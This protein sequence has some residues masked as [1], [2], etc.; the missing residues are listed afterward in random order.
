MAGAVAAE[1]IMPKGPG[2][3]Q[4][5]PQ[6]GNIGLYPDDGS[7]SGAAGW[8]AKVPIGGSGVRAPLAPMTINVIQYGA[9]GNGVT[10]DTAAINSAIAAANAFLALS[11]SQRGCIVYF[12]AGI[13]LVSAALTAINANGIR[14]RGEGRG[15]STILVTNGTGDIFS[16]TAGNEYCEVDN[17]QFFASV[18]R[19]A[20]AFINT[21]GANDVRI[22]DFV[23]SGYFVGISISNSSIKVYVD[24]GVIS[25]A[26]SATA[27]GIL[28]SNGAAGDTYLSDVVMSNG[29]TL[30]LAGI[31]LVQTGH[32]SIH[33]CNI[34]KCINGLLV[35]PAASNDVT[36]VFI[37]TCLFDS[38]STNAMFVNPANSASA[39]FRSCKIVN[40][41]FSGTTAGV[42]INMNTQGASAIVDDISFTSCRVLNNSTHGVQLTF[43]TNVLFLGC[44]IAG[45]S[46]GVSNTNDGVNVAAGIT[47]FAFIGNRIGAVGTAT[48][49]QRWAINV[50][51]GAS[52]RYR[53]CANDLRVNV[54]GALFNGTTLG[55]TTQYVVQ[56][57]NVGLCMNGVGATAASAAINTTDT[58]LATAPAGSNGINPGTAFEITLTGTCTSTVANLS[59]FTVRL[60]TS[61]TTADTTVL[62]FTVTAAA[63][64]TNIPFV[65][66]IRVNWPSGNGSVTPTGDWYLLNNGTTGIAA[67]AVTVT[68]SATSAA[69]TT[70]TAD[71]FL[72]VSYKSAATTTTSTFNADRRILVLKAA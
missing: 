60:G 23:M 5:V 9:T 58:I 26:A 33:D 13:Y 46:T 61:G 64:G 30:P 41:W 68:G 49:T 70:T 19:T 24:H 8:W 57:D 11:G 3:S 36:Y 1:I 37:H 51:A 21:N 42:G 43:G 17:L 52:N 29:G 2:A 62:T 18:T 39:R 25:S 22:H 32:T 35:Q 7:S 47:D 40:S 10:D 63:S 15:A 48:N 44:T 54:T 20:G 38:C 6:S 56:N 59:T 67:A 71:L 53:I 28:V 55:A 4:Q 27:V 34:T 66:R 16:F 31:E 14:I 72:S 45:N 69:A 65:A 12:P 50:L